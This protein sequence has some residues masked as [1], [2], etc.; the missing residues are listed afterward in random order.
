MFYEEKSKV[1]VN[2]CYRIFSI[3]FLFFS[4]LIDTYAN[5]GFSYALSIGQVPYKEFN[6]VVPLFA[7][8]LY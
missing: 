6:L 8:L 3:S 1:C 2:I 4:F 5:F 7:P